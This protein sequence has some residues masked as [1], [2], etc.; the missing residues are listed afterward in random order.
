MT[1]TEH[2]AKPDAGVALPLVQDAA[3]LRA[4]F[5]KNKKAIRREEYFFNGTKL[6]FVQ[7]TVGD[8][9]NKS[10]SDT[11]RAFFIRAM[12]NHTVVPGTDEKV[13]DDSDYE[14]L[15]ELPADGDFQAFTK[16][17]T[18]LMDLNV[19]DAAKN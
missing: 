7:P 1:K 10:D 3:S 19:G 16:I 18:S 15:L 2:D 13:F 8:M 11:E 9:V 12:I 14:A 4:N 17:V 6:E 5:F